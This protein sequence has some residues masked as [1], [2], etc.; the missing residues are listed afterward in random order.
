MDGGRR[1]AGYGCI[2]GKGSGVKGVHGG[3][4]ASTRGVHLIENKAAA[5]LKVK[6]K[7]DGNEKLT[8]IAST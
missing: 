2:S 3:M 4:G 8:I 6:P 1:T 7:T 5:A